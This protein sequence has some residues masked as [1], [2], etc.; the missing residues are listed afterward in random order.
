[1]DG[2]VLDHL[3]LS[4]QDE[5]EH[6]VRTTMHEL[7]Q[8]AYLAVRCVFETQMGS[9]YI[10]GIDGTS[11]RFK[12]HAATDVYSVSPAVASTLVFLSPETA[13]MLLRTTRR[14]LY[15]LLETTTFMRGVCVPGAV[16]LEI[17]YFGADTVEEREDGV[18]VAPVNF[19]HIGHPVLHVLQPAFATAH[20]P[21]EI[22]QQTAS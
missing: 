22:Q 18:R 7:L 14:D 19:V 17:G 2:H 6:E 4:L 13:E 16:P 1:M 21:R 9:K 8:A 3:R 12:R 11:L 5:E 10:V 20:D 15:A